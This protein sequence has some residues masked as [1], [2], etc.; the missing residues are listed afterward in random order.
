MLLSNVVQ[1]IGPSK[2]RI[3]EH[4]WPLQQPSETQLNCCE[5]LKK[6]L[7]L[8]DSYMIP[9]DAEDGLLQFGEL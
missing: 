9:V 8:D 1:C 6:L 3:H 5:K 4:L 2:R 7:P